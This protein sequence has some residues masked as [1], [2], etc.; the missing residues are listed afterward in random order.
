MLSIFSSTHPV[1]PSPVLRDANADQSGI[2]QEHVSRQT[3]IVTV[4]KISC[5][6]G[7][8]ENILVIEHHLPTALTCQNESSD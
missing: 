2:G 1:S 8:I 5:D 3:A 4:K 6:R 7:L